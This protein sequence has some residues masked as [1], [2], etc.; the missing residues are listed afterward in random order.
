MVGEEPRIDIG[1]G[2]DMSERATEYPVT[3][4]DMTV[5][6]VDHVALIVS[7]ALAAEAGRALRRPRTNRADQT[8]VAG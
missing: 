2:G 1:A 6:D 7:R 3:L 8:G 5:N 4:R